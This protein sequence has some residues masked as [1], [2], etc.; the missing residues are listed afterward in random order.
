Y[1]VTVADLRS[2]LEEAS[3][4]LE[5]AKLTGANAEETIRLTKENEMVRGIVVRER[6]EEARREQAKKLMLAE[7]EKLQIKSDTLNQQIELLAQPV[8][9]LTEAELALLRQPVVAVSDVNPASSQGTFALAKNGP[10]KP[11]GPT[12]Q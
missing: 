6:Q 10:P 12:V 8:T 3:S 7:F 11:T 9:K 5:R 1:E 2:Q 4:A